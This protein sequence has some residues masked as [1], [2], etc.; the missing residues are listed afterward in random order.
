MVIERERERESERGSERAGEVVKIGELRINNDR[1]ASGV[2]AKSVLRYIRFRTTKRPVA[3]VVSATR[4]KKER[5]KKI[6][7]K[8]DTSGYIANIVEPRVAARE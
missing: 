2:K 3:R 1:I 8:R 5:K 7:R 6:K 4:R